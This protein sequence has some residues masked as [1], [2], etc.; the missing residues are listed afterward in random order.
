M[1]AGLLSEIITLYRMLSEVD[2]FGGSTEGYVP[3]D[4]IKARVQ[5]DSGQ[6]QVVGEEVVYSRKVTMTVRE[7]AGRT[8][9]EKD[10]ILW[11]GD[12]YRILSSLPNI[13]N[14]SRVIEAEKLN[15]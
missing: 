5:V 1:Q 11:R 15:E 2:E 4:K 6:R 13:K 3:A 10:R 9:S 12:M 8:I 14:Q 7:V